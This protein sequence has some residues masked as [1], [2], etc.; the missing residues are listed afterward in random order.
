MNKI[1]SEQELASE[2]S[3]SPWTVRL[4]R[5][6]LGLPYFRTAGR[7]FYRLESVSRWMD[8]QERENANSVET[9]KFDPKIK[10]IAL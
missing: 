4:W 5:L 7:I 9:D 2:L 1:Y 6:Q 8:A 3:V 10:R